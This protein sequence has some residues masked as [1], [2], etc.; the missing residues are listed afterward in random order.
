M[1]FSVEDD[2]ISI[3]GHCRVED[4]EALVA[5]MHKSRMV[6]IDLSSC[7]SLHSAAVQAILA[8]DCAVVGVPTDAFLAK[9]LT[10]ALANR[11]KP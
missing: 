4:A 9:L 10:P 6:T 1:R 3:N 11:A 5:L 2:V 7:E 8:F